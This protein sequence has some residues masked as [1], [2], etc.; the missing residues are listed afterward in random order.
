MER[1]SRRGGDEEGEVEM[2]RGTE[3]V[4][5]VGDKDVGVVGEDK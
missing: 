1:E 4:D 3:G 2:E 5:Q